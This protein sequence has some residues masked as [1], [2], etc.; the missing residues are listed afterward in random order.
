MQNPFSYFDRRIYNIRVQTKMASN[1]FA[2][3]KYYVHWQFGIFYK[4]GEWNK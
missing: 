2:S 4:M 3:I 1:I